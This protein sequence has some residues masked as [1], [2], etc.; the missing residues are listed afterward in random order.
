MPSAKQVS[1]GVI[2]NER[3]EKMANNED[4]S[5]LIAYCGL[6]CADCF[7]YKGKIADLSR[8]LRKELRD[9]KF[10]RFANFLSTYSFGAVYKDYRKCY[11][12]LGAML[13][14]R[15]KK[16]CKDGGGPPFCK[17]RKC[18]QKKKINGCWECEE[19]ETCKNLDFLKPVHEDGHIKNLRTLKRKGVKEFIK[20]KRY[21]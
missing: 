3:K 6:C 10:E 9:S 12:V 4:K 13:R 2:K 16:G 15:C 1:S 7:G 14:F 11:E 5:K 21:W 8:D 20:G 17:M 18:C 19:F